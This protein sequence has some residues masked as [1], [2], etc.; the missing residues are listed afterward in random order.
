MADIVMI[1]LGREIGFWRS[2]VEK[3]VSEEDIGGILGFSVS[4]VVVK[5][6]KIRNLSIFQ[7]EMCWTM[8]VDKL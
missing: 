2:V 7:L 4:T 3:K 8:K 1:S 5:S 6:V